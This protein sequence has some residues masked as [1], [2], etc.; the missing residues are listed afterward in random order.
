MAEPPHV[1]DIDSDDTFLDRPRPR[2]ANGETL[3][4]SLIR[5]GYDL[6]DLGTLAAQLQERRGYQLPALPPPVEH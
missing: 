1:L 5:Q 4:E 2:H 6:S 3:E